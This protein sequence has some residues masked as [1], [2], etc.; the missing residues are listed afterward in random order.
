M[1]RKGGLLSKN[2]S[3]SDIVHV[4]NKTREPQ[5]AQNQRDPALGSRLSPSPQTDEH[6]FIHFLKG[7]P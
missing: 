5:A 2:N 3:S 4:K 6:Y 7:C 1:K